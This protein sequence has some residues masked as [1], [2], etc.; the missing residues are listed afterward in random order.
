MTELSTYSSF[1]QRDVKLLSRHSLKPFLY[2]HCSPTFLHGYHITLTC[3]DACETINIQYRACQLTIAS[4][5]LCLI[6]PICDD[7]RAV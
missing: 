1:K 3:R 5:V 4:S 6:V 7:M 2:M